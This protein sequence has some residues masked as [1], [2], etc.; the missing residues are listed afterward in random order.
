MLATGETRGLEA[1]P[2]RAKANGRPIYSVPFIVFVDDVS[3]NISKQWNKHW[4]CYVSNASLPREHL[5][6]PRN[7]RFM[8]TT[9]HAE[10]LEMLEGIN[11]T[12]SYVAG[13]T[14]LQ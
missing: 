1:H 5:N 6:Q 13:L 8:S 14:F 2:L 7:V 11:T 9:Q 10:P 4:C 3:G 12:F